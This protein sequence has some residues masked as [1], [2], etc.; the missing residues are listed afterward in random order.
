MHIIASGFAE[1][2]GNLWFGLML[3]ACGAIAGFLWCRK[4][5]P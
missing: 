1:W 3:G 2:L 4:S 5:K